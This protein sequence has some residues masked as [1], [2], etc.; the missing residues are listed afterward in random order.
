MLTKRGQSKKNTNFH[1]H[2]TKIQR[3]SYIQT[4]IVLNNKTP[5]LSLGGC[6]YHRKELNQTI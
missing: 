2:Q 4:S 5:Y 6:L 1:N 3:T